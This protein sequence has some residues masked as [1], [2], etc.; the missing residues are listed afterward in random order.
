MKLICGEMAEERSQLFRLF[1]S[2][3]GEMTVDDIPLA[4]GVDLEE[5]KKG[6]S[7]PLQVVVEV[8]AG[9]SKRGWN[10]KPKSLKDIVDAVLDRTLS[11]FLG[12]QRPEDVSTEFLPPVTHWI[13]AKMIGDTAYFRGLVDAAAPDLKRWIRSK[14]INQVSIFGMPRLESGQGGTDV[15]GYEPMS[16][17]W[18]PLGRAGMPTRIV[19][20]SGEMWD[21]QGQGPGKGAEDKVEWAQVLAELKSRHGNKTITIGMIAGEMGL[22]NDQVVAELTPEFASRVRRALEIAGKAES[23]LGV[24][25]EMDVESLF[26]HLKASAEASAASASD[27]VVGEMLTAKLTSDPAKK[28]IVNPETPLGK[29]WAYH[30]PRIAATATEEQISGEIDTFLADTVVKG[31]VSAYHTDRNTGVKGSQAAAG[32][33]HAP[34]SLR[35]KHSGI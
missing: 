20:T 28:D 22:T 35:P 14:R 12:H 26:K 2:L 15:V 5:L 7:D 9:K 1:G 21:M 18:T 3:S 32:G 34:Q 33:N 31:I 19:A 11:G 10:Y 17:D 6:D 16:I 8:P 4:A 29:L 30:R 27:Q 24:T 13:G 23:V 25:G